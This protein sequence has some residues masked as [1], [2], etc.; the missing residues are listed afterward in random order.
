MRGHFKNRHLKGHTFV[1]LKNNNC[2]SF[3]GRANSR[4]HHQRNECSNSIRARFPLKTKGNKRT[5]ECRQVQLSF[6]AARARIQQARDNEEPH[7]G[8]TQNK[9][10]TMDSQRVEKA[11][12]EKCRHQR[13]FTKE[14]FCS[15][16]AKVFVLHSKIIDL[17]RRMFQT[18]QQKPRAL[19]N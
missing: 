12:N 11:E 19:H 7:F 8:I 1:S 6:S 15:T 10:K 17:S 13:L 16:S 18:P 4:S 3:P 2:S 14:S 9:E 5:I